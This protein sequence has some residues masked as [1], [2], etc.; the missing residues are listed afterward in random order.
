MTKLAIILCIGC[1]FFLVMGQVL[2]KRAMSPAA[3]APKSATIRRFAFGVGCLAAWF[4]LWL[5]LLESWPLSKLFPFEGMNPAL[6]ALAAWIF[7]KERMPLASWLG[8][9]MITAGIVVVSG[10]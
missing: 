5:G 4:F 7:L 8:I 1:Q 2:L 10:S 6:M 9:A 3:D